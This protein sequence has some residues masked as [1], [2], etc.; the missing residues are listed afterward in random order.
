MALPVVALGPNPISS[1]DLPNMIRL[2]LEDLIR[3]EVQLVFTSQNREG[4]NSP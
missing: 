4:G 3:F 2:G 1:Q